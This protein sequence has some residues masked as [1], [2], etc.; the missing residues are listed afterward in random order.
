MLMGATRSV[1]HSL[2]SVSLSSVPDELNEE[3]LMD[4][5]GALE[6]EIAQE[7]SEE[8]P[9]YLLNAASASKP[10]SVAVSSPAESVAAAPAAAASKKEVQVDAFGLPDVPLRNLNA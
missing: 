9:A 7:E 8:L 5:L 2:L 1:A 10:Q 3:D 4:E 6:D